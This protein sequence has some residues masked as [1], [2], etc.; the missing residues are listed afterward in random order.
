[1]R[2]SD[3][4][5]TGMAEDGLRPAEPG[6]LGEVVD[7]AYER[8]LEQRAEAPAPLIADARERGDEA[9]LEEFLHELDWIERTL[10]GARGRGNRRR[11]VDDE[12]EQ[13]RKTVQKTVSTAVAAFASDMPEL[14]DHLTRSVSLGLT[15]R[16]APEPPERWR[17]TF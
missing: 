3:R 2:A 5:T 7:A 1:M 10:R 8:Q 13:A 16:Y 4:A 9:R 17:V 14:H 11:K 15:C 12:H 6:A